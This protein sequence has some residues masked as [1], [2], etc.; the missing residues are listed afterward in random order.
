MSEEQTNEEY[1][2]TCPRCGK[3]IIRCRS[4]ETTQPCPMCKA[5]YYNFINRDMTIRLPARIMEEPDHYRVLCKYLNGIEALI[6]L[7]GEQAGE[8]KSPVRIKP[9]PEQARH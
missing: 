5:R 4:T 8:K 6:T 2:V 1:Y 7:T 3:A 9:G